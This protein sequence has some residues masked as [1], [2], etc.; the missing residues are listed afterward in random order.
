MKTRTDTDSHAPGGEPPNGRRVRMLRLTPHVLLGTLMEHVT[1]EVM[2]G[3]PDDSLVAGRGYDPDR[4]QFY[5]VVES[6][7]F[8]PVREGDLIPE[9]V[10]VIKGMVR[11]A[12]ERKPCPKCGKIEADGELHAMYRCEGAMRELSEVLG[13]QPPPTVT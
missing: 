6:G 2:A 1:T 10:P 5:L 12:V 3:L 4:D 11:P 13:N 7:T 9:I 8:E